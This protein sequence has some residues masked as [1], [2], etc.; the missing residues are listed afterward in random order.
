MKKF[1]YS[2]PL[3]IHQGEFGFYVTSLY[4][5]MFLKSSG[6]LGKDQPEYFNTFRDAFLFAIGRTTGPILNMTRKDEI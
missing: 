4:Q 5:K 2:Q 1:K 6:T 3:E